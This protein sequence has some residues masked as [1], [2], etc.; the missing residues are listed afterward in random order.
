MEALCVR[1]GFRLVSR[2]YGCVI[3]VIAGWNYK[4]MHVQDCFAIGAS[5]CKSYFRSVMP[6]N[7]YTL[8]LFQLVAFVA[9]WKASRGTAFQ[10]IKEVFISTVCSNNRAGFFSNFNNSYRVVF[11][12]LDYT[13]GLVNLRLWLWL[14]HIPF[15]IFERYP[16]FTKL[17]QVCLGLRRGSIVVLGYD[18]NTNSYDKYCYA[19]NNYFLG[20]EKRQARHEYFQ[21]YQKEPP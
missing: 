19:S 21:L 13:I 3:C 5:V 18:K 12:K 15:R 20:F 6:G 10:K 7:A 9:H 2:L 8:G 16:T 4:E 17:L 1:I 14:L 11:G